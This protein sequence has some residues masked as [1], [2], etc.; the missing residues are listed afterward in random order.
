MILIELLVHS[1]WPVW[2]AVVVLVAAV[3]LLALALE[4]SRR[5]TYKSVLAAVSDGT[6]LIDRTRHGRTLLVV[7]VSD[8]CGPDEVKRGRGEA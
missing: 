3:G 7:R 2:L 4:R 8:N 1:P 5:E 6:L